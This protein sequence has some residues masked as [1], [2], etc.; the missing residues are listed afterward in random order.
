MCVLV[1]YFPYQDRFLRIFH[2]WTPF[3]SRFPWSF[4]N[5]QKYHPCWSIDRFLEWCYSIYRWRWTSL[6]CLFFQ[7]ECFLLR[8]TQTYILCVTWSVRC[9]V[10]YFWLGWERCWRSCRLG[11]SCI[12]CSS[13]RVGIIQESFWWALRIIRWREWRMVSL[14]SLEWL[15]AWWCFLLRSFING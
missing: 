1:R 10:L 8:M 12:L 15:M 14:V 3:R 13:C 2:T 7:V 6:L 11:W 4:R 9:R 5:R